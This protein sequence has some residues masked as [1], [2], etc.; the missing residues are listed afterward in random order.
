MPERQKSILQEF[1]ALQRGKTSPERPRSLILRFHFRGYE[2]SPR[3]AVGWGEDSRHGPGSRSPWFHVQQ[4]SHLPPQEH[5]LLADL[6]KY[7][8]KKRTAALQ[9]SKAYKHTH[10]SP[11]N[12]KQFIDP[13]TLSADS[14]PPEKLA[15]D[16]KA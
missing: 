2:T 14:A 10:T 1:L 13:K 5:T 11:C 15:N 16:L 9:Q 12:F 3:S 7:R 4:N 6:T 8:D